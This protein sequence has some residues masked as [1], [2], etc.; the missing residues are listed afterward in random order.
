MNKYTYQVDGLSYYVTAN[1]VDEAKTKIKKLNGRDC[2]ITS[3]TTFTPI[4]G[5]FD[6]AGKAGKNSASWKNRKRWLRT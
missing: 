3:V 1:S 5:D 6:D 2:D 4:G